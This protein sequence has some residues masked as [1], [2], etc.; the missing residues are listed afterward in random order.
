[1]DTCHH[2][3]ASIVKIIGDPGNKLRSVTKSIYYVL[4]NNICFVKKQKD[5]G[6]GRKGE[7]GNCGWDVKTN[8]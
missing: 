5:M 4:I 1:M 6:T 2:R 7:R 8:K 3:P